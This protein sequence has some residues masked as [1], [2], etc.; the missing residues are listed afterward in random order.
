VRLALSY[1][2]QD[3]EVKCVVAGM[4]GFIDSGKT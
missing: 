2:D 4:D 3:E 1:D